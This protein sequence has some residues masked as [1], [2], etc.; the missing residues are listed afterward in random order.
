MKKLNFV[1]QFN[2]LK[3]SKDV[4]KIYPVLGFA[5]LVPIIASFRPEEEINENQNESNIQNK[6]SISIVPFLYG[7]F[8]ENP[9]DGIM[10]APII[11]NKDIDND[12]EMEEEDD[13]LKYLPIFNIQ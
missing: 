8:M 4:N 1:R 13:R 12:K 9:L 6:G 3:L 11:N 5:S 2:Q 10:M 7:E